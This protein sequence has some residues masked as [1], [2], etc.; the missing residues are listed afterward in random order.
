MTDV[1]TQVSDPLNVASDT[2]ARIRTAGGGSGANTACWLA[3]EGMSVTFCGRVGTDPFGREAI[4]WLRA[5]GV[6]PAVAVDPTAPTGTCVVL[7]GRDGERTMLPDAGAN[8]FLVDDDLPR[9]AFREGAHL[10]LSGYTLLNPGSRAAGRAALRRGRECGMTVSVDAS[11]AAPLE[12]VGAKAFLSWIRHVDLLFCNADEAEVLM[13][14]RSSELSGQFLT[15]FVPEVVV[16]RGA[17]GASWYGRRAAEGVDVP[18]ERV[19]IVDTVGAG[20]A[21]AAGF[22]SIWLVDGAPAAAL[23]C[24][25]L[26][27]ARAVSQPG[28]RP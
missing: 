3:A 2:K 24:G 7:V 15:R 10:H 5:A 6:E 4:D 25:H 27:A 12:A 14:D 1:L 8:S 22:L 17:E 28:A 23:T 11:S 16:K 26:L 13:A 18:A 19:E 21:F 9:G 20:D